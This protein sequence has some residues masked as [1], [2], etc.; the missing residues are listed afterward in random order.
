MISYAQ[1]TNVDGSTEARAP[2]LYSPWQ[3]TGAALLG[4][5]PAGLWLIAGNFSRLGEAEK[6]KLLRYMTA[7]SAVAL[8]LWGVYGPT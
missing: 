8:L 2:Y 7:L 6:A 4:G 5:P 1:S 3:V